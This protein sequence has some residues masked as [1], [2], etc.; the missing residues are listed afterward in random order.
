[1]PDEPTSP[2]AGKLAAA[3]DAA[4]DAVRFFTRVPVPIGFGP[5]GGD[6]IGG[7]AA[8]SPLAGAVVGAGSALALAL[9]LSAGLP[10]TPAA[11]AAAAVAA[12]VSG[13][14]HLD[15]LA[16]VADGFGGGA[17]RERKLD[18][19]RD[20]RLGSFGGAALALAL[21]A[22]VALVAGLAERLDLWG[23]AGAVISAAVIARPLAFLPAVL[24]DPARADG[25][26]R[27]A[28]PSVRAV[29]LGLAVAALAALALA[30]AGGLLALVLGLGAAA[31]VAALARRQI[32]GYTGDVCGAGSELGE[33]AAL[34]GLLIVAGAG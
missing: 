7:I 33:I 34:A 2:I 3:L 25:L 30:G 26:G 19:M 20:S 27:A 24:L 21:M 32:G 13:A 14:L 9:A 1:M 18:I 31:G 16:D 6:S 12:L 28:R 10:A 29:A 11:V 8:A 15:G 17:T 23:A 4:A 5:P 22:R